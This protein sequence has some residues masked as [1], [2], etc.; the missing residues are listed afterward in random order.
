[1]TVQFTV[2]GHPISAQLRQLLYWLP[3]QCSIVVVA[4]AIE[5]G[6]IAIRILNI[7]LAYLCFVNIEITTI[8][9]WQTE[10]IA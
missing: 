2:N 3:W 7:P 4:M 9:K 1:M 10:V 5:N 6:T 8:P